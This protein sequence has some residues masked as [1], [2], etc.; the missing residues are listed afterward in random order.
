MSFIS[1]TSSNHVHAST[2]LL[3]IM[4]NLTCNSNIKDVDRALK[5]KNFGHTFN[6]LE[7]YTFF[8]LLDRITLKPNES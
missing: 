8:R 1:D 4:P 6:S 2:A 5:F 3:R 7:T